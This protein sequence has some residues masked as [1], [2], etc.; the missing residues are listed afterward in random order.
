MPARSAH[1]LVPSRFGLAGLPDFDEAS[2]SDDELMVDE[3]TALASFFDAANARR[4]AFVLWF[5]A[6][7]LAVA[8]SFLVARRVA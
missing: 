5:F 1:D 4:L 3:G 2:V 6:A 8:A 7:T